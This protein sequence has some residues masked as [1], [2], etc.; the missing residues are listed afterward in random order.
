MEPITKA[1]KAAAE[2]R[3]CLQHSLSNSSVATIDE[4]NGEKLVAPSATYP[5]DKEILPA[6]VPSPTQP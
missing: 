1:C 2:H 3:I 4:V 5:F 6:Y